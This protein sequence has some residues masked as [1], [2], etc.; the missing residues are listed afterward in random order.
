[1]GTFV[2]LFVILLVVLFLVYYAIIRSKKLKEDELRRKENLKQYDNPEY[3]EK[4]KSGEVYSKKE[5]SSEITGYSAIEFELIKSPDLCDESEELYDKIKE[6]DFLTCMICPFR[7]PGVVYVNVDWFEV[8]TVDKK[9]QRT[10]FDKVNST[11]YVY[12]QCVKVNEENCV[13]RLVC[14]YVYFDEKGTFKIHNELLTESDA[15][16]ALSSD[17]NT[18]NINMNDYF[19]IMTTGQ[20][21]SKMREHYYKGGVP[22]FGDETED[23][24]DEDDTFMVQFVKDYLR[25]G[26]NSAE[27]KS[28]FIRDCSSSRI[29]GD[30]SVLKTRINRYIKDTGIEFIY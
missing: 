23:V 21:V 5:I 24:L 18:D 6:G 9:N 8:G 15:A 27:E 1:M 2:L 11:N 14:R 30:S 29:Y 19:W 12:C 7:Q 16:K 20:L 26:I 10:V 13:K 22:K 3:I 17:N 4:V 28:Q 25:G